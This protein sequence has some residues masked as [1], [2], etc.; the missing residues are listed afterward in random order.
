MESLW[1]TLIHARAF[2][3]ILP[4]NSLLDTLCMSSNVHVLALQI[5]TYGEEHLSSDSLNTFAS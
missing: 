2:T 4:Q 3:L 1:Y 5:Y